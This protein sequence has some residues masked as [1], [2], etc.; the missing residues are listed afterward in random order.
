MRS[1]QKCGIVLTSRCNDIT[2]LICFVLYALC[3][4]VG[5]GP[6]RCFPK[7]Y[8]WDCFVRLHY[9]VIIFTDVISLVN[10]L[11]GSLR[12]VISLS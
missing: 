1:Q 8:S 10:I 11:D 3:A 7:F 6:M 4:V 2:V 12:Y 5:F 9:E